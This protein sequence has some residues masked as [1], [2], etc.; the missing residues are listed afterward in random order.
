MKPYQGSFSLL[1]KFLNDVRDGSNCVMAG[2]SLA[3]VQKWMGHSSITTTIKHYGHL[4]ESFRKEEVKKLEGRMDTC[5]D[6]LI[7]SYVVESKNMVPPAGIEPATTG[8]GRISM[9]FLK[10]LKIPYKSLRVKHLQPLLFY[11]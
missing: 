10:C 5:M 4:T 6:T 2:V 9:G 1:P 3:T 7:N 11:I 8:L